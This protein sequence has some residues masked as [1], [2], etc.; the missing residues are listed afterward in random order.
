MR[1]LHRERGRRPPSRSTF[2]NG[3]LHDAM[4][5]HIMTWLLSEMMSGERCLKRWR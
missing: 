1:A 2:E 4:K 3:K 5:Q